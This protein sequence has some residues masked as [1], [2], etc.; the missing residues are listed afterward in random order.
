MTK[1][2]IQKCESYTEFRKILDE[3]DIKVVKAA[4]R[5]ATIFYETN[6]KVLGVPAIRWILTAYHTGKTEAE[7]KIYR[8]V[9]RFSTADQYPDVRDKDD[10][11]N[12]KE[13]IRELRRLEREGFIVR[14]GEY[15]WPLQE[16]PSEY[17]LLLSEDAGRHPL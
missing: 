12:D 16:K 13:L 14:G 9:I 17:E 5:A 1:A 8:Y 6:G 11:P 2:E 7:D 15:G 10:F 3:I 4:A